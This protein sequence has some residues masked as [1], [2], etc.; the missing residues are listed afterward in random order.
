MKKII[1]F[2]KKKD[3]KPIGDSFYR[4]V[5]E[6]EVA[7]FPSILKKDICQG[8]DCLIKLDKTKKDLVLASRIIEMDEEEKNN[9][10]RFQCRLCSE[11][12]L[13]TPPNVGDGE[14]DVKIH[15]LQDLENIRNELRK[16][17]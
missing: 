9:F 15:D 2:S 17:A 3:G 16:Y 4:W 1:R 11:W 5:V 8:H 10:L 13:K 6:V 7:E 14:F 12:V